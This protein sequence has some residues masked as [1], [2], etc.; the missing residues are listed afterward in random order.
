VVTA[1][2]LRLVNDEAPQDQAA[3]ARGGWAADGLAQPSH[4]APTVPGWPAQPT[5]QWAQQPGSQQ[6]GSPQP[7]SQQPVSGQPVSPGQQ[8]WSAAPA[9][10]Q[11][12]P[13]FTPGQQSAPPF[14]HGQQSAPPF[15][16]MPPQQG[17]A[18]SPQQSAPPL[19]GWDANPTSAPPQPGPEWGPLPPRQE[20][21]NEPPANYQLRFPP[22]EP[23]KS[24]RG[25]VIG[26]IVAVVA[27]L[28]AGAG[29]YF[30]GAGTADKPPASADPTPSGSA[31]SQLPPFE[32]AQVTVNKGKL[33]GELAGLAEPWLAGLSNCNVH[34]D[35]SAPP[36]NFEFKNVTCQYGPIYTQFIVYKS[37]QE[38]SGAQR[39][40]GLP[41]EAQRNRGGDRPGDQGAEPGERWGHEGT[42]HARGVRVQADR[43]QGGL[44]N[45]V[46][47]RR[48]RLGRAA[49]G[50]GVRRGD[51]R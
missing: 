40:P 41:A 42:W 27:V 24:R 7:G 22:K 12:S 36:P 30:I 5:Q 23:T 20:F 1:G 6:P 21:S 15:T 46:G 44:R 45:L 28:A 18:G 34:T 4:E 39:R 10:P 26:V 17:W 31:S 29:G 14:T 13:P 33:N 37:L 25:T 49:V 9:Y 11:S 38:P 3:R 2:T 32:A 16:G 19:T 8:P 47:P 51:R 43:R 50:D 35:A 48:G